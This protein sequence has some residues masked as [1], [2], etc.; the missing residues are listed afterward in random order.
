MALFLMSWMLLVAIFLGAL[1]WAI[2]RL[3]GERAPRAAWTLC[4]GMLGVL[5]GS[6]YWIAAWVSAKG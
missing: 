6:V 5:A 4:A 1:L 3:K 2:P